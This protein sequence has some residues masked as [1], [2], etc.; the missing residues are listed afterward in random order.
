VTEFGS[1]GLGAV[2]AE[3]RYRLLVVQLATV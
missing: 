3:T 2:A 1:A